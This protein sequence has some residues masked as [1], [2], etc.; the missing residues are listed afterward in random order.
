MTD[1]SCTIDLSP[2]AI[3]TEIKQY[4]DQYRKQH[5]E[6][7]TVHL[8]HLSTE[9]IS[10]L[11]GCQIRSVKTQEQ[12]YKRGWA[13][14]AK[15]QRLNR[16]MEYH[17]RLT[18]DY[19]LTLE[20]QGQLKSLFYEGI[21]MLVRDQVVYDSTNGNIVKIEGLKRDHDHIFF[22][23]PIHDCNIDTHIQNIK[24]FTPVTIEQLSSAQL[25]AGKIK[26]TIV[27]K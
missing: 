15:A 9:D 26:P 13:K 7:E 19:N 20:Q 18:R 16:L 1:T 27:K 5:R 25:R 2:N 22:F 17:K 6:D 4:L 24:K 21:D 12:D 8:D 14:L 3:I 23:A 10:R 11:K